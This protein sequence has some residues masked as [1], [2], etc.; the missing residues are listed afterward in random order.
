MRTP[1]TRPPPTMR[2]PDTPDCP[3][4]VAPEIS[5]FSIHAG[6]IDLAV[7]TLATKIRMEHRA[8]WEGILRRVMKE[9]LDQ[10]YG[11]R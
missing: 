7:S 8:D 2:S 3:A 5:P 11:G 4:E 9:L 10:V 6:N 1:T